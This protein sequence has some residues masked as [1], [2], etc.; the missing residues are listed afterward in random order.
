M[1]QVDGDSERFHAGNEQAPELGEP[2]L[3]DTVSGSCEF[4]IGKMCQSHHAK[5]RGMELVQRFPF[6][7]K[8]LHAFEGE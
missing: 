8:G 5:S 3:V 2:V 6:T 7:L 1:G 4:V